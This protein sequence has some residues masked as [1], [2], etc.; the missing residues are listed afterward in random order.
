VFSDEVATRQGETYV[1]FEGVGP[2]FYEALD[3]RAGVRAGVRLIYL[4]GDVEL[5]LGVT[6]RHNWL[7]ARLG[8]LVWALIHASDVTGEDAG[9]TT[10]Y[11]RPR[12]AGAQADQTYYFG[13]NAE[14]MAGPKNLEPGVD[15][16]PDLAVEVEVGNPVRRALGAW[17][18]LGVPEVWHLDAE[19]D[20]L[21]LRV[22]RLVAG[23]GS[24]EPVERSG[25]FPVSDAELLG[26]IRLAVEEGTMSWQARLV[27][28]VAQIVAGRRGEG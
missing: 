10:Y 3:A 11:S 28:R 26:L 21:G 12:A 18:R 9:H 15:P 7:A 4:D 14:R 13:P 8:N 1:L 6:R 25:V 22:L 17:A 24:Y 20:Q 5:F 2:E 19:T 27:E 16:V 23:G